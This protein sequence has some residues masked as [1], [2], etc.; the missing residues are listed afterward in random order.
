MHVT[1][2]NDAPAYTA[3]NHF[4]MQ[5]LRLQGK[6]AGPSVQM[7][8]GMSVIAP[9]GRTALDPS[10]IEKLYFVAEG[11]VT[12]VSMCNGKEQRASLGR[13][14]SCCFAPGEARQ[15]INEG[16]QQAR[17]VLVMANT[18]PASGLVT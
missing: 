16:K 11:Q 2:L 10:P 4:G 6:E 5:C 18:A 3:P 15:L 13:F 14:D 12:M 9:G 8:M 7:W 1:R 17:V